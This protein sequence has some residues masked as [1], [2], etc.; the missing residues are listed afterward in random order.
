LTI[1]LRLT[2]WYSLLLTLMLGAF[3][4][5]LHMVLAYSLL[6]EVDGSIADRATQVEDSIAAVVAARTDPAVY[7]TQGRVVLPPIDVFAAP[8]VYVQLLDVDGHVV[9]R[10]E[11]LGQQQLPLVGSAY[12][13]AL[14]GEATTETVE[15]GGVRLRVL[16]SPLVVQERII[17]LVQVGRSL[18]EVDAALSRLRLFLTAGILLGLVA[19]IG[20]GALI[21][22]RT[23]APIDRIARTAQQITQAEDLSRRIDQPGPHD[24]VGRLVTTFNAMLDRLE[25]LFRAQQRFVADASHELRSPLTAIRGNVDLLQRGAAADPAARDEA[26]TAIC[27]ETTRMSRLVTDLLTLAQADA[28]VPMTR[29]TVELDALLLDVYRQ[30]RDR[31]PGVSVRL[32]HE[33][34]A[35]AQGDP[36]RLRQLFLNLADNAVKYTPAGGTVTLSLWREGQ[37]VRVTVKDTGVGIAP[38]DQ[39]HVFE[40]FYRADKARSR[41]AGGTGLGLAIAR[42]IVQAHGG[43]IEVESTLGQGSTFTVWLPLAGDEESS[44][45]LDSGDFVRSGDFS[46]LVRG[47]SN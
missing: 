39:P 12:R 45:E 29:E 42:W 9:T 27:D 10:S 38:E 25:T 44:S 11:N 30:T 16:T 2:I 5:V 41:A 7:L 40:R 4:L 14:R 33:D 46:R 35:L 43:R 32:G 3:A 31:A 23:L 13:A 6:S 36:D 18:H 17:G 22:D 24:E 19:A 21:A 47:K 34:Q 26:L 28:G 1:R 15:L 20:G 37:W 8:G